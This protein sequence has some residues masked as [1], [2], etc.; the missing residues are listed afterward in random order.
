MVQRAVGRTRR[1][2]HDTD[3]WVAVG[4]QTHDWSEANCV[5]GQADFRPRSQFVDK[6][7]SIG[8]SAVSF[9][10]IG[11]DDGSVGLRQRLDNANAHFR[12]KAAQ[13]L[14]DEDALNLLDGL[15]QTVVVDIPDTE[16]PKAGVC[17]AKLTAANFCEVGANVIYITHAG[18][19]FVESI[20]RT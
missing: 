6:V 16:I 8:Y 1:T 17:L 15:Y 7:G 13:V 11:S 18:R 2:S 12:R 20:K 3:P 14:D 10:R 4:H 19:R 5:A 9:G